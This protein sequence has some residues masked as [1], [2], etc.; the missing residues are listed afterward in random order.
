MSRRIS[1]TKKVGVLLALL[2][3]GI[4][5]LR[6]LASTN[7]ALTKEALEPALRR[8]LAQS[9]PW[10]AENI[11]VHV[12]P[13]QAPA[14]P[15]GAVI[16]KVLQ[17]SSIASSGT[18]NFLVAAQIG[19]REQARF[20][21]RSEVRVFEQAIVAITPLARL[22]F[23][24]AADVRL[25][26]REIVSRGNRSFTRADDVIGKQ[27]TRAIAVNDVLTQASVDRPVLMKRGSQVTMVFES[28]GLRVETA[29]I[30]EEAGKI[31]DLV[32]VKNPSSG[33]L[34]RATVLDGRSVRVN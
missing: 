2:L 11:D 4:M 14:V 15:A 33:K 30:A 5:P 13:F 8:Y 25:E 9:G 21:V 17:P 24:S 6:A 28:A 34:L 31:G 7:P 19:G 23:I 27:A 20:W 1:F 3:C 32:Q 10:S 16:F 18:Y 12:L 26:R 22:D 29:G